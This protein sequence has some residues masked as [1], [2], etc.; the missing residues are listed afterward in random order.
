MSGKPPRPK[1][2][3]DILREME[4]MSKGIGTAS[5]DASEEEPRKEG[6][7]ALK[8]LLGFF[9]KVVPEEGEDVQPPPMPRQSA[10]P[11]PVSRQTLTPPIRT[12]P[13]VADLVAGEPPPTF[14]TPKAGAG[15]LSQRAFDQIY[16]EAGITNPACSVDELSQLME[17]PAVANQP[18]SV[19]IIAVNLTLSAKGIGP[20]VPIADAVRKDR[21]LDGYQQMLDEKARQTEQRNL[22]KIQLITKDTEEYLKRRQAEME[23]LR[24]ETSEARRQSLDFSIRREEE[25]KRMANLISP[26]LEGKPNPVSV[27]SQPAEVP[28]E[29]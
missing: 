4:A 22:E 23:A 20:D 1:S 26:F 25:E 6:G 21:A 8:S 24:A 27:G 29:S 14:K 19:K 16:K 11:P 15:D 13:R 10:P 3:E 28:P 18:L 17:N 7:G 12:G 5:E 2:T 9:V